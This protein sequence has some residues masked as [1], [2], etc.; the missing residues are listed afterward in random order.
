MS[1]LYTEALAWANA[2]PDAAT[3]EQ[4][5]RLV[6][7]AELGDASAQAELEDAFSGTLEFGTAGLRAA[8]GLSLIHI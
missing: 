7:A 5:R 8:L 6:A 4:L 1:A 2:D 3:A